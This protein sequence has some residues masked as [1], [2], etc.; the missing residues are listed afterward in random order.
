MWLCMLFILLEKVGLEFMA[1][2]LLTGIH[3]IPSFCPVQYNMHAFVY[4]I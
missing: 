4:F 2:Q 1:L 3:M